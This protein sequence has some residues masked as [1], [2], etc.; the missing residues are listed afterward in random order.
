M[1]ETVD[2]GTRRDSRAD[3]FKR[4]ATQRTNAVIEKLRILGNCSNR[5]LYEYSD[6]D[7]RKVFSAI[8]TEVRRT[9]AKF[10]DTK[11]ERF[12]L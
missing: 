1:L 7:V 6:D 3:T 5:A 4:L 2:R 12:K 9:K 11:K 10:T 8:E